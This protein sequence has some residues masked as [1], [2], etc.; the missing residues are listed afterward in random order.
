[1]VSTSEE[2]QLIIDYFHT[3]SRLEYKKGEFI[4]GPE[5]DPRGVFYIESGIV[6]S[7]DITKYGEENLLIVRKDG[8]II[9]LTWA[10]TGEPKRILNAAIAPTVV[11]LVSRQNFLKFIR[12]HPEAILPILDTVTYM[13]KLHS[14]RIITLEYRSVR[15]RLASFLISMAHRFGKKTKKGTVIL[16]PLKQQDIASSISATRETTSRVLR[17]LQSSGLISYEQS[18]ITIISEKELAQL[19]S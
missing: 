3:G 13:Y 15:E 18:I 19:I 2:Q 7:Y 9:G 4:V 10:I 17:Q 1:M 11:W 12:T 14:D 6:K 16:A 5:E 8:E